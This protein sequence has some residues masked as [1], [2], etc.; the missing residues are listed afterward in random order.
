MNVVVCF[1]YVP[2]TTEV[3]I[4]PE[5][6]T[7]IR[8]GVPHIINPF[9]ENAIEEGLRIVA[10]HGG[11]L[12]VLTMGPPAAEE[13]LRTALAMGADEA[14]LVCG[15][16]FAGGDTW[17]TSYTLAKAIQKIGPS[18]LII[19]GK[20]AIDGDTAQVGP[21]LAERLAIPQVTYAIEVSIDDRRACVKRV[22]DDRFEVVEV[23]LPALLT[24]VKQIN[25]PRRPGLKAIRKAKR[26]EITVWSTPA[27]IGADPELCGFRGSP[28]FVTRTFV[29]Q[30]V[31]GGEILQGTVEG[32]V[33]ALVERLGALGVRAHSRGDRPVAQQPLGATV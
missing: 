27:E 18:D 30:R 32:K 26:A 5:T 25:E 31:R 2:D 11:K 9:D 15:P 28:T 1:K 10:Q 29:P 12:S 7:L 8:E 20:Q 17:A 21:G 14:Y 24:V 19:C 33:A 4:D 23:K 6:N 13:G 3:R 22:L 16:Q